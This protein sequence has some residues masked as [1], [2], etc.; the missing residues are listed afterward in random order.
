MY[1]NIDYKLRW[2]KTQWCHSILERAHFHFLFCCILFGC[3]GFFPCS[4]KNSPLESCANWTAGPALGR[5]WSLTLVAVNKLLTIVNEASHRLPII[6]KH[7][8]VRWH[9]LCSPNYKTEQ[10]HF[11][12]GGMGD[13]RPTMHVMHL[14]HLSRLFSFLI[15]KRLCF[16][17]LLL[18]LVVHTV[19]FNIY[20]IFIF[21]LHLW[22]FYFLMY[23]VFT[24]Y[25]F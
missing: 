8:L 18:Y 20:H 6:I 11:W 21:L 24:Y 25:I 5:A 1:Q 14:M 13:L 2:W 12:K 16:T 22:L 19:H 7:E 3:I 9:P 4:Q 17:F 23:Y 10:L 15:V